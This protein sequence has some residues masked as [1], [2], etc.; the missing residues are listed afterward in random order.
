MPQPKRVKTTLNNQPDE[1][2]PL[3]KA[4]VDTMVANGLYDQP[5]EEVVVILGNKRYKAMSDE[6]DYD[7]LTKI[8]VYSPQGIYRR[9]RIMSMDQAKVA[10]GI[11]DD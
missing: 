11:T 2:P 5:D 9:L 10:L 1:L 7:R 4:L 8:H 3:A 6:G